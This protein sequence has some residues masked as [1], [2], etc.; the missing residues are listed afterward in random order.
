MITV[1]IN[2]HISPNP[3]GG[4]LTKVAYATKEDDSVRFHFISYPKYEIQTAVTDLS[5]ILSGSIEAGDTV[6]TTGVG[7]N[8]FRDVINEGLGVT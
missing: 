6:F 8:E 1:F 4:T 7:C 5:Q 3:I 2:S